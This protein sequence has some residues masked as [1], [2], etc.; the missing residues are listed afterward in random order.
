MYIPVQMII[1]HSIN[2]NQFIGILDDG[3]LNAPGIMGT[4]CR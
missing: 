2:K 3:E 1:L 4:T